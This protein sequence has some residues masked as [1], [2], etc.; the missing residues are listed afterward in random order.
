MAN[1]LLIHSQYRE[2][3]MDSFSVSRSDYEST[4]RCA[5]SL[6]INHLF[7]KLTSNALTAS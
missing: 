6:F 5:N 3:T 1:S 4:L 7:Y 2:S